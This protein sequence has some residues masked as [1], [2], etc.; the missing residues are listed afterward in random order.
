MKIVLGSYDAVPHPY[1]LQF[2][3]DLNEW[4]ISDINPRF[5]EIEKIDARDIPYKDVEALYASHILEHIK[6]SE[7]VETLS[8]W[9][10]V[11]V[12]GGW[13]Q[14]NV[15]DVTYGLDLLMKLNSGEDTN[16]NYFNDRNKIL[17]IINGTM[18]SE[19]DTHKSWYTKEKLGDY[20]KQA[21]FRTYTVRTEFEA[22]D[23]RCVIGRAVK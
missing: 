14:I 13:V 1:H 16:N 9:H 20:L 11:L 18:E 7:V 22:H 10:S 3:G 6:E 19:Y 15:P 5:P 4:V 17:S 8:H 12:K 2:L 23:M 21:G